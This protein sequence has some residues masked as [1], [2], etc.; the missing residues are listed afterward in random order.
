MAEQSKFSSISTLINAI[1]GNST[2]DQSIAGNEMS[3]NDMIAQKAND[4]KLRKDTFKKM[5]AA[6]QKATEEQGNEIFKNAGG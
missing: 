2:P 4:K 6:S 3:E 5:L 1:F